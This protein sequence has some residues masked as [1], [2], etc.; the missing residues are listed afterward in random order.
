M[1]ILRALLSL[2]FVA[3]LSAPADASRLF[4]TNTTDALNTTAYLSAYHTMGSNLT[5]AGFVKR[6]SNGVITSVAK[7]YGPVNVVWQLYI[8]TDNFLHFKYT[9]QA[10]ITSTV[11][12]TQTVP[13]TGWHHV[14]VVADLGTPTYIFYLD[15]VAQGTVALPVAGTFYTDANYHGTVSID[16]NAR[17]A[18]VG[19]WSTQVSPANIAIL[20]DIGNVLAQTPESIGTGNILSAHLDLNDATTLKD[21]SANN[22]TLVVAGTVDYDADNPMTGGGGGGGTVGRRRIQ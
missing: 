17:M 15:G 8:G 18:F 1:T 11:D 19:V 20:A 7:N 9:N 6:N 12:G 3:A 16:R 2:F 21:W 13:G 14:A 4:T 10:G 5:L 22:N